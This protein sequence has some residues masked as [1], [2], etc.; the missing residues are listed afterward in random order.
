MVTPKTHV[1]CVSG[2]SRREGTDAHPEQGVPHGKA[3][4]GHI[5]GCI[6]Q[7]GAMRTG[8]GKDH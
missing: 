7:G 6:S 4:G 3:S 5:I 1:L 2:L 8:L